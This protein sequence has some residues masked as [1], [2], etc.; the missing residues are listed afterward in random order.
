MYANNEGPTGP[1]PFAFHLITGEGV[2]LTASQ[3]V[4]CRMRAQRASS[5]CK[6]CLDMLLSTRLRNSRRAADLEEAALT[7]VHG[8]PDMAN[9]SAARLHSAVG[10]R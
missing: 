7:S 5:K 10:V 1:Y 6:R 8:L 2:Y 3:H 9:A 4:L